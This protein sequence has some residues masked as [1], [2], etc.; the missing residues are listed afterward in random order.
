MK[1]KVLSVFI[2]CL[3]KNNIVK[4]LFILLFLFLMLNITN[5][6]YYCS[7][8]NKDNIKSYEVIHSYNNDSKYFYLIANSDSPDNV[9]LMNF[10]NK[11]EINNNKI[12]IKES[13]IIFFILYCIVISIIFF[14]VI[15]HI[16]YNSWN[17]NYNL[18]ESFCFF[19]NSKM[20][21]NIVYYY[22]FDIFLYKTENK[23]HNVSVLFD[24]FINHNYSHKN[25]LSFK[26]SINNIKKLKNE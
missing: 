15:N 17:Y 14:S 21:N 19:I 16:Y 11:K 23:T 25:R 7:Q 4:F 6:Q 18:I 22:I 10:D 9:R 2:F 12:T 5:V 24:H 8:E 1:T 3:I 13:G 20:Y 26:E